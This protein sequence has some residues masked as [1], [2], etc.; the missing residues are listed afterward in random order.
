MVTSMKRAPRVALTALAL[1][2]LAPLSGCGREAAGGREEPAEA[3]APRN[4]IVIVVDALRADRVGTY[5]YE[6]DTTPR[7]DRFAERSLVFTRAYSAASWTLPS[8]GSLMTSVYPSVHGLLRPPTSADQ[9]TLPEEFLTLA[10]SLRSHG[11]RTASITSQPWISKETGLTQGFDEI[12]TVAHASAPDEARVLAEHLIGWL[13]GQ[14]ETRFFLYAHFMGPHSPYDVVSEFTGRFTAGRPVPPMVAEFH[15]LYEFESE[16][17]AYRMA[18]DLAQEN[19][20]SEEEIRY[21]ED[22]YDEKLA[23][24]DRWLGALFDSLERLGHLDDS[25]IVVTAD[26][27]ES[28]FEH[29]TIFHG[30]HL[31]EELVRVPLLIR[32]PGGA[33]APARVDE[34]VELIDLYP[35]IHEMLEIPA[36]AYVQGESLLPVFHG[37]PGDG[38]AFA[39]CSGFK[40]IT[41]DW[42][43]LHDYGDQLHLP[44][45]VQVREMY[46]LA[47]DPLEQFN[48]AP[49]D[50]AAERRQRELAAAIWGEIGEIRNR[51]GFENRPV[52]F[53]DDT[54]EK[55]ASLGYLGGAR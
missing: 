29:G 38:V 21:L 55:L 24:T 10:E 47:A 32:L 2:M 49:G 43:S 34:I 51:Y 8:V 17:R 44:R 1:F 14:G 25:L 4:V 33:S 27:G 46:D 16:A 6:R 5:G 41:R 52:E 42:S 50:R 9:H 12:R 28:F 39:E 31:H 40:V 13:E 53:D 35:T 26:H 20:L 22:E 7:I 36:P 18:S 30:K 19:R 15:R 54:R 23:F 48:L 37:G 3:A 11:F 45:Q